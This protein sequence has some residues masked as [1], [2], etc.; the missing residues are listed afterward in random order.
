MQP[1]PQNFSVAMSADHLHK[2][3]LVKIWYVSLWLL[4]SCRWRLIFI[5]KQ[6]SRWIPQLV[7]HA[8][9]KVTREASSKYWDISAI[10][11]KKQKKTRKTACRKVWNFD[12]LA[13]IMKNYLRQKSTRRICFPVNLT[14]VK[15]LWTYKLSPAAQILAFQAFWHTYSH[16]QCH[17][18]CN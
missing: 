12:N 7:T 18:W 2:G 13:F 10:R 14:M 16:W 17:V 4:A 15:P 8:A 9:W 11:T 5:T 3:N 1:Y 6:F